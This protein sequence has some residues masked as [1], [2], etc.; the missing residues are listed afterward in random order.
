MATPIMSTGISAS[1][2]TMTIPSMTR[3]MPSTGLHHA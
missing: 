3:T 2:A 1:G